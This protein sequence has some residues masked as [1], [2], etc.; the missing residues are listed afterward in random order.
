MAPE[1]EESKQHPRASHIQGAIPANP[2]S[3]LSDTEISH[4]SFSAKKNLNSKFFYIFIQSHMT[5]FQNS[6]KS[7]YVTLKN[8]IKKYHQMQRCS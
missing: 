2:H 1:V 8:F 3:C 4:S 6:K 5:L 7:H